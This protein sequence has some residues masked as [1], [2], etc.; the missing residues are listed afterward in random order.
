MRIFEGKDDLL[1]MLQRDKDF[2]EGQDRKMRMKV[3]HLCRQ[4]DE[5]QIEAL[6]YKRLME[7][8]NGNKYKPQEV[9]RIGCHA[10][11]C[12]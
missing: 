7:E 4:L 3:T 8:I 9:L 11:E 1:A 5:A 10:I 12:Q 6:K 2:Y